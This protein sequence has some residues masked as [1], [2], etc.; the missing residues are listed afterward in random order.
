[1]ICQYWRNHF[2]DKVM[3]GVLWL[4]IQWAGNQ[5]NSTTLQLIPD[6][7]WLYNTSLITETHSVI[8]DFLKVKTLHYFMLCLF[9]KLSLDLKLCLVNIID[10][11]PLWMKNSLLPRLNLFHLHSYIKKF[12]PI[13]VCS[14]LSIFP[15][16]LDILKSMQ[17]LLHPIKQQQYKCKKKYLKEKI[18]HYHTGL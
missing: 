7:N 6:L 10:L 8:A 1:M 16:P 17:T 5:L 3:E 14:P 2:H 11:F 13:I 4:Y 9:S 18:S 15:S 12:V